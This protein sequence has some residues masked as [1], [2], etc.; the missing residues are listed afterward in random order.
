MFTLT[1]DQRYL[2]TKLL[3]LLAALPQ[4]ANSANDACSG[5]V[6]QGNQSAGISITAPP[7]TLNVKNLTGPIQPSSGTSGIR[8]NSDGGSDLTIN[9]GE[10]LSNVSIITNQ[11]SGIVVSSQG[12]PPSPQNDP[13]LNIPIP[14]NPGVSGGVVRVDSYSDITTGGT[15]AHGISAKSNTTGYPGSVITAL[16]S[17][18]DAGISFKVTSVKKP[19]GTEGGLDTSVSARIAV[20]QEA[21]DGLKVFTGYAGEAG[22]F[23]ISQDGTISFDPG[24][25]FNDLAVGGSRIVSVNY[26]LDGYRNNVLKRSGVKGELI[27]QVTRTDSGLEVVKS[28]FFEDFGDSTK[29]QTDGKALPDLNSYVAGRVDEATVRERSP[30]RARLPMACSLRVKAEWALTG[31]MAAVSG[32]LAQKN[33]Q[34][35]VLATRAVM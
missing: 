13:L 3:F 9:S 20:V 35:G 33:L 2:I 22:S 4:V 24:T 31:R 18:S 11:A 23:T 8:L 15:N 21:A 5:G 14:G 27:A 10:R 32:P 25:G 17:F 34:R 30:P 19:D 7:N 29:P 26:V 16:E 6:C 12:S 28:A 1:P